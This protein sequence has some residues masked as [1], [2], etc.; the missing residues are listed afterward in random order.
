VAA[1][2]LEGEVS[3]SGRW[4]ELRGE[5]F[6]VYVAEAAWGGGYYTWC[7]GPDRRTVEFYLDP[8]EAI[9]NGLRRAA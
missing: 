3:L 1:L 9:R 5:R 8:A 4:L 2:G 7:D 6:T